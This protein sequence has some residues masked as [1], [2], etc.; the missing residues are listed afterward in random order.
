MLNPFASAFI[1]T[2]AYNNNACPIAK[3]VSRLHNCG[4]E[5]KDIK[6]IKPVLAE[7]FSST[8]LNR[9][10][11]KWEE[12]NPEEQCMSKAQNTPMTFILY[13]VEA[14]NSRDLEVTELTHQT[15]TDFIICTEI[16]ELG[17][18]RKITNY[19]MFYQKGT[20][21][22]GGVAIGVGKHLQASEVG[23]N[24]EN[25]V[26]I[27]IFGLNEPLRVIGLYWPEKQKRNLE[28]ILPF[29]IKNTIISGD[30]NA[31]VQEWNSPNTDKRGKVVKK[32]SEENHLKY[33]AGTFNSSKRSKRNIDLTFANF[34]GLAGETL[35][36]GTSDHW[37]I[38]YKSELIFLNRTAKFSITDWKTYELFLCIVQEF[39]SKQ[40]EYSGALEWYQTYIR[41]ITALKNRLTEWKDK[42]K[43]RPALPQEII[44]KLKDQRKVKSRFQH[45]RR[46]EDRIE[47]RQLT[48]NIKKE[49]WEYRS[50]RWNQFISTIQD[51]HSRSSTLFWRNT[52]RIYKPSTA[53]FNK[54]ITEDKSVT[55]Q[56]DI[57]KELATHY[58]NLY[59]PPTI[60]PSSTHDMGIINEYNRIAQELKTCNIR[61]R[62]TDVLEARKYIKE[63]KPKKSSGSDK[64]SNWMIKK[65][66]V[67]Y[68]ECLTK[69]FN[70]WLY[71]HT[72]PEVWKVAKI[73]T[74]NK[75]KAGIPNCEQTRP[76][77]LLAT[78]SKIYEKILLD[79]M[80]QWAETNNII[81]KEQS[82]FR[83]GCLLQTRALSILQEVKNNLTGNRPTLG[84]YVDYKK[85]YDLVWHEGLIVKLFRMQIPVELL[86]ILANWLKN[87]RAYISFG[88]NESDLFN[89]PVGLPQGSSLSPYIFILYHADIVRNVGAHSTHLFADDLCTL[90]TPPIHS[91]ASEMI[92]FINKEGSEV[93]QSLYEYSIKWKQPINIGKTVVQIF[94]SQV[95]R[96]QIEIKMNNCILNTVR[97]FKYLGFTLT[98]KLSLKHTVIKCMESVQKSYIKL[99][100][101]QR[102]KEISTKVLRTCF[103]AYAFPFFTWM[104]PIYP[105]LPESFQKI[106][107]RKYRVGIRLV[108]RCPSVSATDLSVVTK[109]KSLKHYICKYLEKRL[110]YAHKTD[111]GSSFFYED[112]FEW[113]HL[114]SN[115]DKNKRKKQSLRVGHLFRNNRVKS[116][117]KNHSSDIL[118]WLHFIDQNKV[119]PNTR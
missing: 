1:P 16:G 20:N 18:Q 17:Q 67:L 69:C 55:A 109:E 29:I 89:L 38:L 14:L 115:A 39:W 13:N 71:N 22:N 54:L 113:E 35:N 96:P 28:D 64:V 15:E 59:S 98:D 19:N 83:K 93:C 60:N 56:E 31:A 72:Y 107:E 50:N 84:I 51:N 45:Y 63:L 48:R 103:F 57:T 97:S 43:W 102:N 77:S 23:A 81:P 46:E 24:L 78:H 99:K 27:D 111:L 88:G 26:I 6:R 34:E 117:L 11:Q 25:T 33:V 40:L 61:I 70:T 65:L 118:T 8:S 116:M 100:W 85:A 79:R 3:A 36:F 52:S 90:I 101:L 32:W 62:P 112:M 9:T 86:K 75:L 106:V 47:L 44:A 2:F 53:P 80:K 30:F 5:A 95:K 94:H 82:G 119:G 4:A 108:H 76:I 91:K 37:P 10:L 68:I 12:H 7:W 105:L 21:K 110:A 87:R 49:I 66:P 58:K 114:A 92:K 41:F 73:I 42:D 104:F 74:L